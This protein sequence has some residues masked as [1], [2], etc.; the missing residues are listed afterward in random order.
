MDIFLVYFYLVDRAGFFRN[1]GSPNS[2]TSHGGI[3][4]L[5]EDAKQRY[6]AKLGNT[7]DFDWY[8]DTALALIIG[9]EELDMIQRQVK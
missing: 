2:Y 6:E 4:G 7:L 3:S 8:R 9:L 5:N 1:K